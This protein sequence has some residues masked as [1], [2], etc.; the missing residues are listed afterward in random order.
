MPE[1][2]DCMHRRLQ[3]RDSIPEAPRTHIT[4]DEWPNLPTPLYA[5]NGTN[6]EFQ[7]SR[8]ANRV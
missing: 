1:A 6:P 7:P 3:E 2:L 5:H 8:H 4:V